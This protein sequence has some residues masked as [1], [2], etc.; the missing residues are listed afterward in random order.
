MQDLQNLWNIIQKPHLH[1]YIEITHKSCKKS[2]HPTF[3]LKL[4]FFHFIIFPSTS[5]HFSSFATFFHTNNENLLPSFKSEWFEGRNKFICAIISLSSRLNH[6]QFISIDPKV[7]SVNDSSI[8]PLCHIC[9]SFPL[10]CEIKHVHL[11]ASK[12]PILKRHKFLRLIIL[13]YGMMLAQ[14]GNN[15]MRKYFGLKFHTLLWIF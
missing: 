13:L 1:A 2:E 10:L 4:F 15:M 6:W 3:Y 14:R 9:H 8:F 11:F 5:C 7:M 12:Y